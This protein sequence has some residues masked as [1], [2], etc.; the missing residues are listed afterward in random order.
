MEKNCITYKKN[1]ESKKLKKRQKKP[2]EINTTINL[3]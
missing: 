2:S 1:M 3:L